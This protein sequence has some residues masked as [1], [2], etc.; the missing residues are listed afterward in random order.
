MTKKCNPLS[1]LHYDLQIATAL[2][3]NSN[4]KEVL[5]TEI[6]SKVVFRNQIKAGLKKSPK[7]NAFIRNSGFMKPTKIKLVLDIFVSF[8]CAYCSINWMFRNAELNK[9]VNRLHER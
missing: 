8:H 9:K 2:I 5:N 1:I 7:L 4:Y 6:V 3:H